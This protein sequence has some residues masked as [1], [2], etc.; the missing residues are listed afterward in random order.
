MA[1]N[2]EI[3][4]TLAGRVEI[5]KRLNLLSCE[6]GFLDN[7]NGAGITDKQMLDSLLSKCL[8]G[9]VREVEELLHIE[10]SSED[11]PIPVSRKEAQLLKEAGA[12][13]SYGFAPGVHGETTFPT[14][15]FHLGRKVFQW[16]GESWESPVV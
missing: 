11:H 15:T 8:A 7:E 4:F 6:K 2:T 13:S 1:E 14:Q 3:Y 16:K 10:N 9:Q 12:K 5:G